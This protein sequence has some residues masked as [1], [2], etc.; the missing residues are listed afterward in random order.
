[1]PKLIVP[2]SG[3]KDSQV[4]LLLALEQGYDVTPIFNDTG[5]EHP[6]TYE[7][8][9]Y[10]ESRLKITIVRTTYADAPTMEDLIRKYKKFPAGNIRFCTSSFK[11]TPLKRYLIKQDIRQRHEIWFGIRT[12]ESSQRAKKYRGINFDEIYNYNDVFPAMTNKRIIRHCKVRF[13]IIDWTTQEVFDFSADRGVKVNP[14][15][16]LGFDRVGCF[17]CL[18]A[19]RNTIDAALSTEY[20]REQYFKLRA[21]EHE[22]GQSFLPAATDS[23]CAFCQM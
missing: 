21:L 10:L 11:A 2:V 23:T 4:C 3:G 15:Y 13:P 19:G 1:M 8:L 5:W 6:L 7:H 18:L 17:P 9:N 14:L 16:S 22:I 20:G 12:A